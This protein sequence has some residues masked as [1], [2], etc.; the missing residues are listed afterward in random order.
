MPDPHQSASYRIYV[1]DA[2]LRRAHLPSGSR[3]ALMA[4]KEGLD[5]VEQMEYYHRQ[6][7]IKQNE[8]VPCSSGAQ[9]KHTTNIPSLRNNTIEEWLLK[10]LP[11]L[12]G[13]DLQQ[14]TQNLVNDG[15]D[16]I[17]LIE[18]ELLAEDL[19]FM[20][21]GHR[22]VVERRLKDWKGED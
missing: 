8:M 15:F 12:K 1:K 20:K 6:M 3:E 5:E 16:S 4:Y 14:Y 19:S 9:L 17:S 11:H 21:K 13:E 22:I 10:H 7:R 2:F 18:N